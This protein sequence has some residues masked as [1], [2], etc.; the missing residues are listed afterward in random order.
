MESIANLKPIAGAKVDLPQKPYKKKKIKMLRPSQIIK[1]E[2][3]YIDLDGPLGESIGRIER[4]TKIFITGRSYSGKSSI[5]IRLCRAMSQHMRVDYNNHEEKGG[6]AATVKE[7]MR[8]AGIDE[9]HDDSIRFYKAPITSDVE[10]TFSEIL[11][12][13][14][15]AGFAVLDS[16]QHAGMGK[17]EYIEFTNMFCNPR[18]GKII[19]FISHWQKNDL[20]KHLLHDCDVKLEAMH[21]VVYVES[22]LE[23]ATN[24]PIVIW[25]EG[26]KKAWGKNYK[27]VING[28]YWPGRKNNKRKK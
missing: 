16:V 3:Q 23:G 9:S 5:I 22:R 27:A 12:K 8:L 4:G 7:K 19:A 18:R 10:E 26:A 2:R 13:R 25:E 6:D 20:T 28:D 24:K 1:K 21:Y 11:L 15:S 14:N 17:R